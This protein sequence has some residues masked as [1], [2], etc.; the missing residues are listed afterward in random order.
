MSV[1]IAFSQLFKGSLLLQIYLYDLH[2]G[3]I[4]RFDLRATHGCIHYEGEFTSNDIVDDTCGSTMHQTILLLTACRCH[5]G[6]DSSSRHKK[7]VIMET[8]FENTTFNYLVTS[9]LI[10]ARSIWYSGIYMSCSL[11][12]TKTRVFYYTLAYV[13]R[14]PHLCVVCKFIF[15][16]DL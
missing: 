8:C 9:L 3:Q 15:L 11:R 6:S 5:C 1:L 10:I 16:T 7:E 13:N 12:R 14:I 4:A 2:C